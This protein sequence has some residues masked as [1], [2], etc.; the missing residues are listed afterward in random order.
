METGKKCFPAPGLAFHTPE[1]LWKPLGLEDTAISELKINSHKHD[2][3]LGDKSFINCFQVRNS[4][5]T[6]ILAVLEEASKKKSDKKKD[7][8]LFYIYRPNTGQQVKQVR[9]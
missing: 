2:P 6:A 9:T 1:E 3:S 4:K 8:K 5:K 7:S